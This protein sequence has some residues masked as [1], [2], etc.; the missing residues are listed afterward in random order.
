MNDPNALLDMPGM[1]TS[2]NAQ[3]LTPEMAQKLGSL[4][5]APQEQ[6]ALQQQLDQAI[7]LRGE[8]DPHRRSA[9]AATYDGVGN[10]VRDIG[11]HAAE[12]RI[13]VQQ[14]D[15]MGQQKSGA[16]DI[17]RQMGLMAQA[18]RQQQQAQ[19]QPVEPAAIYTPGMAMGGT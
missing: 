10:L 15:L 14:R 11:S 4:A 7:A 9:L 2:N 3:F 16:T 1:L 5:Y 17:L 12:N 19:S 6:N 13:R 8:P 18:L